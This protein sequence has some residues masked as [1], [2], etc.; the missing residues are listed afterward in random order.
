MKTNVETFISRRLLEILILRDKT[1][2]YSTEDLR[3][4]TIEYNRQR[5]ERLITEMR[6]L[7]K[8]VAVT[9]PQRTPVPAVT[10]IPTAKV[11]TPDTPLKA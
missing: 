4:S 5:D 6:E 2:T 8:T 7:L 9:Q 10:P 1:K 3:E 11:A